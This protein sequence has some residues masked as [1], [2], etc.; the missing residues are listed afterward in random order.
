MYTH[1]QERGLDF[2]NR[3]IHEAFHDAVAIL[4]KRRRCSVVQDRCGSLKDSFVAPLWLLSL[5]KYWPLTPLET[6][7]ELQGNKDL[8]FKALRQIMLRKRFLK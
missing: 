6:V 1:M 3:V 2:R 5:Y 4:K 8:Y 7:T